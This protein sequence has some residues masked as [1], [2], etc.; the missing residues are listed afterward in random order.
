[1]RKFEASVEAASEESES[2]RAVGLI[3][4]ASIDSSQSA[5]DDDLRSPR[6]FDAATYPQISALRARR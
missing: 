2:A 6:F 1:L 3:E 5:R 4:A